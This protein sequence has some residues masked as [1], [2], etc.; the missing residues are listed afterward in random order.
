MKTVCAF[1]IFLVVVVAQIYVPTKMIL[2]RED[3][4]NTGT[5]YKFKTRPMDPADPFRGKYIALD[6]EADIYTS[7][8]SSWVRDEKVCVYLGV[9]SL[10]F[11]TI[12]SVS[13][14]IDPS[15]SKDFVEAKAKWYT[16][17]NTELTIEYPFDR[18]YMEESKA[19]DAEV[20]VRE[21]QNDSLIDN[22]YALVYIKDGQAV[23]KDVIIYDM[24]IKDYV[25]SGSKNN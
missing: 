19:Y 25:E 14:E 2:N 3:T 18:F 24:S 20:A 15:I 5:A 8:D 6:F 23:L 4:L 10:G 12:H 7:N 11:A 22:V 17:R 9:D 13:K 21:N 1:I 16:A